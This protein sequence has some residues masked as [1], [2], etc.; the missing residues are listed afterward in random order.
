MEKPGAGE[1]RGSRKKFWAIFALFFV[2]L[3]IISLYLAWQWYL[4]PQA[5]QRAQLEENMRLYTKAMKNYEDAMRADTY[6]SSTP[7]GTLQ[8]FIDALKQGDVEL[9]S[10]YFVYDPTKP[11]SGWLEALEADKKDG[12]FP[13]IISLLEKAKSTNPI[14]EGYFDFELRDDSGRLVTDVGMKLNTYS[15]VWKIESM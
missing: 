14:M 3:V 2:V 7:E 13:Q 11:K 8:M 9:A 1:K 6:G 10:Q 12:S 5:V 4:S 15:G